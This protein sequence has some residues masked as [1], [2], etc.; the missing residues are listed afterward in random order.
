MTYY[1]IPLP[2]IF[3]NTL[4]IALEYNLPTIIHGSEPVGHSYPGKGRNLPEKRRDI[5]LLFLWIRI[6]SNMYY[7]YQ[8]QTDHK[9]V[10]IL[11][12]H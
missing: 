5:Q 10:L 12:F 8:S 4:Q 6:L 7:Y 3:I 2:K 9:N 1:Y 11:L